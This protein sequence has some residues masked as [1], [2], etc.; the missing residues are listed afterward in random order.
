MDIW[1]SLSILQ[2]RDTKVVFSFCLDKSIMK[3]EKKL[4]KYLISKY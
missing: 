4:S 1:R 3:N 2:L